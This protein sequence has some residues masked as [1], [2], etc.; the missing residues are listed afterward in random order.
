[1]PLYT[2]DVQKVQGTEYWT[3]RYVVNAPSLGSASVT[4]EPLITLEVRIHTMN[5]RID[6]ARVRPLA[7]GGDTYIIIPYGFDGG[8]DGGPLSSQLP[9]FN[10][11]R[12]D[13]AVS[14]GRPSR[15]Y[16]RTG[17]TESLVE[18]STINEVY[19]AYV[20]G[21]IELARTTMGGAF[22]DV[23]G[24]G[25][26]SATVFPAMAMRQLRRGSRRRLQPII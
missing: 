7:A 18:G 21:Q 8:Y 2:V 14:E 3:N 25:I 1:M 9:L 22:V 26:N 23:D 19:R 6:R 24:Q 13:L 16:Y 5:V 10:V 4:M 15:K 17:L 12:A 11:V 20:D